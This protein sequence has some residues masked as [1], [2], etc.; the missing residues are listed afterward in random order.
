M[1]FLLGADDDWIESLRYVLYPKLHPF[2]TPFGGY[3]VGRVGYDQYVGHFPEDE[4][5]IEEELEAVGG[6]RNP[7]AALKSLHDGRVSE[8]SWRFTAGSAAP[9]TIED[10]MQLHLTLFDRDDGKHGREVYAHY[11]DD[12][13][14]NAIGHLRE[15][16]FNP[17]IGVHL[18]TELLDEHTYL[19]RTEK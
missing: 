5:A 16:N 9:V 3:A 13:E 1:K 10:G 14:A 7:I 17:A 11:E 18:A 2:L 12:W 15:H 8:G 19:Q 6:E 4:D